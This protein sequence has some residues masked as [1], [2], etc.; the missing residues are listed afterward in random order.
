MISQHEA[1]VESLVMKIEK[2]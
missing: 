2:A 1:E